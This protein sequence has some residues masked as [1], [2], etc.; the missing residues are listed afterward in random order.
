[1]PITPRTLAT[2]RKAC[3]FT[4]LGETVNV[5]YYP[6]ALGGD[7]VAKAN[8]LITAINVAQA[9]NDKAAA[10][11][12]LLDTGTWLCGILAKWDY[13]EDDG[14]TMQP[15]TPENLAQQMVTFTDFMVAMMTAIGQNHNQGNANGTPSSARSGATSSPTAPSASTMASP[16]PSASVSSPAGSTEPP[17]SN[18]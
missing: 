9:A 4:Y 6:A 13:L 12:A 15:I 1:M 18:G 5:E 8:Q 3:R 11:K 17:V 14:E 2:L 16:I 10:D 7:M